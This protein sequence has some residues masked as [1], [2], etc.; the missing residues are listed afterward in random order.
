[1]MTTPAVGK[2]SGRSP[3]LPFR[4]V[5]AA[6]RRRLFCFHH[7]GGSA[8]TFRLWEKEFSADF[9][10][11]AVQLPGREERL[12]EPPIGDMSMLIE[13]LAPAVLPLLD[14]PFVFFGHSLGA[15]VAFAL[16]QR[17]RESNASV[18]L[19][20]IVSGSRAPHLEEL[21]GPFSDAADHELIDQIRPLG[22]TSE[23]VLRHQPLMQL[24]L[25]TLRS[26][27]HMNETYRREA[28]HDVGCPIV[29]FGG[30][31]DDTVAP[32]SLEA[33]RLHTTGAFRRHMMPGGHFFITERRAEFLD[34]MRQELAAIS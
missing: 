22:G 24:V 2:A 29:V 8:T 25:P 15:L 17:L 26:D 31:Q 5:K 13:G 30:L 19:S 18:P 9:E 27:L 14:L 4:E 33:W 3:W 7:A 16:A 10:V 28:D 11:C 32:E 21:K 20:L 34:L 23:E 6:C 12:S 1:M